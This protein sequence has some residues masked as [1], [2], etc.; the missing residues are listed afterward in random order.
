MKDF[1]ALLRELARLTD[2][3]NTS[4]KEF[5]KLLQAL[6]FELINCGSAGH[7]IAKHPAMSLVDYPDYNCGH[8]P[9][10]EIK[11]VYIKKIYKFVE[12]HKEVIKEYLQ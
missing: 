1:D 3:G 8:N 12:L 5:N 9:G 11:R 7:K 10:S 6:G 2:S 4:C